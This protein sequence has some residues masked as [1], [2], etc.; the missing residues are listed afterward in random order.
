MPRVVN[1]IPSPVDTQCV[2]YYVTAAM[3]SVYS[4]VCCLCFA[5]ALDAIPTPDALPSCDHVSSQPP[6]FLSIVCQ[7]TKYHVQLFNRMVMPTQ[8]Q[9]LPYWSAAVINRSVPRF[10]TAFNYRRLT[11]HFSRSV[12]L[13]DSLLILLMFLSKMYNS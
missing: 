4:C 5:V 6:S 2:Q 9:H 10:A 3:A 8:V 7:H 13:A 11:D 12:A 1:I